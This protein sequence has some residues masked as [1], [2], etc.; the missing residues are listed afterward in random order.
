MEELRHLE[1]RLKEQELEMQLQAARR[2]LAALE[3]ATSTDPKELK[4]ERV[5]E[6][7]GW[8]DQADDRLSLWKIL[9]KHPDQAAISWGA[10]FLRSHAQ[11]QWRLAKASG[12]RPTTWQGFKEW[13]MDIVKPPVHRRLRVAKRWMEAKQRESQSARDFF[14]HMEE[15]TE[16]LRVEVPEE[17]E[18]DFLVG[19]MLPYMQQGYKALAEPPTTRGAF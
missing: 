19:K 1:N 14:A 5:S 12:T 17:L 16:G 11:I 8:I 13:L 3:Q 9:D 18:I 2:R 7:R 6:V 4:C 15:L 10:G